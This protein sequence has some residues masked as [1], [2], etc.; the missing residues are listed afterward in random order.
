MQWWMGGE[1]GGEFLGQDLGKSHLALSQN[2]V[3]SW[4]ALMPANSGCCH[5]LWVQIQPPLL[6]S[7]VTLGRTLHP[8]GS[9]LPQVS[10]GIPAYSPWFSQWL[11][12]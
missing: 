12:Q 9:Q 10:V 2:S 6:S 8:S 11:R 5:G 3:F 1:C 7:G 4:R